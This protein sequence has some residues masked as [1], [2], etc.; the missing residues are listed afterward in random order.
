MRP[1]LPRY[2]ANYAANKTAALLAVIAKI[3]ALSLPQA[4]NLALAYSLGIN[5]TLSRLLGCLVNVSATGC[6]A[7]GS[8][9]AAWDANEQAMRTTYLRFSLHLPLVHI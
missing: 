1:A 9:M 8:V 3:N 7:L 6:G 5:A 2:N 4:P